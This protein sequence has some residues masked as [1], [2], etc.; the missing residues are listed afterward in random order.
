MISK[1]TVGFWLLENF[2][3]IMDDALQGGGSFP[4]NLKIKTKFSG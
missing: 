3:A 4:L 2:Y 1:S